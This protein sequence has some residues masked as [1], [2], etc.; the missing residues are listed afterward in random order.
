MPLT[1]IVPQ[2]RDSE[3]SACKLS[4]SERVALQEM[5]SAMDQQ[6]ANTETSHLVQDRGKLSVQS[7]R[8]G[9]KLQKDESMVAR[10][11]EKDRL[12]DSV[13]RKRDEI[14]KSVSP[15]ITKNFKPNTPEYAEAM[16]AAQ[17][18]LDPKVTDL[19]NSQKSDSRRLEPDN[20]DAGSV[21]QVLG[22]K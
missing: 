10:G 12:T 5:K 17:V 18:A 16:K 8:I 1:I 15:L 6:L 21:R 3:P 13:K 11:A 20:P 22:E 2:H 7:Q 14:R 19:F 4:V 9:E